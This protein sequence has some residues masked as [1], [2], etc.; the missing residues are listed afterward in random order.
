MATRDE[1]TLRWSL[2]L[3][4][5]LEW[6][7]KRYR[8][9]TYNLLKDNLPL[10]HSTL[11][12]L[13][14]QAVIGFCASVVSDTVSNSL[15]VVKT[16]RQVNATKISYSAFIRSSYLGIPQYPTRVVVRP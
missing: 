12:M 1:A 13:L 11:Q 8:F 4:S 7:T 3:H 10:P 14:R 6:L 15:R 16:Y 9:A 2:G 5:G